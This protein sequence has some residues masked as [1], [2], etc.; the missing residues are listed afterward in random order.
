VDAGLLV[1]SLIRFLVG[2]IVVSVF[3]V[4]GDVIKP[5]SFAGIFSAAPSVALATVGL[6]LFLHGGSYAGIEGR[7]MLI[8]GIALFIAGLVT[9]WLILRRHVNA[10]VAAGA[11]WVAWAGVAFGIWAVTLR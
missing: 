1:E 11:S 3:S 5:K 7:S 6:T 10:L 4:I 2:G 9:G 8:G